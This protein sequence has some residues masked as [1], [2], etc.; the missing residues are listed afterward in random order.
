[1]SAP[2]AKRM[3]KMQQHDE[4]LKK[5]LPELEAIR[6]KYAP[7]IAASALILKEA[8]QE[9]KDRED[10]M[11]KE[12]MQLAGEDYETVFTASFQPYGGSIEYQQNHLDEVQGPGVTDVI[13]MAEEMI[14][15]AEDLA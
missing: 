11:H 15:A 13:E 5:K 7:H 4:E 3:R 2:S 1:M 6:K 8:A 12:C 9:L 14:F 10:E